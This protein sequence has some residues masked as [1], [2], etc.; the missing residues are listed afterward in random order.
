M[1]VETGMET[2]LRSLGCDRPW[3]TRGRASNRKGG[4]GRA[5]SLASL[6]PVRSPPGSR[7]GLSSNAEA[8]AGDDHTPQPPR[9]SHG[10]H[11]SA[12]TGLAQL[13]S[14]LRSFS[15]ERASRLPGLGGRW[16]W[17]WVS[18][19]AMTPQRW[20]TA[21]HPQTQTSQ[22]RGRHKAPPPGARLCASAAGVLE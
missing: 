1:C 12:G 3:P 18:G 16:A 15:Q 8:P 10:R 7:A 5:L 17:P 19:R 20:R 6:L 14:D 2:R 21:G 9:K 11:S 22:G 13:P 4:T